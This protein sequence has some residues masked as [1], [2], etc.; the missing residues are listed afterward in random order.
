MNRFI[1][2]SLMDSAAAQAMSF[3]PSAARKESIR[4]RTASLNQCFLRK[5]RCKFRI[6]GL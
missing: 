2:E 4:R 1:R 3:P 5:A 6:I